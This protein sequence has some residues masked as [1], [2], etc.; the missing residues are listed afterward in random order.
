MKFRSAR[1][2][3]ECSTCVKHKCLLRSLSGHIHARQ[4]QQDEYH[5][6]L[7]SQY[8]DRLEYWGHRGLSRSCG[9]DLLLIVDGM[10]QGKFADPRHRALKAKEFA[11]F[12]R[13]RAHVIGCILHGRGILFAVT[14]ADLPKD[15]N[16]HV[17]LVAHALTWVASFGV[18]LSEVAVTL[19]CDNTPRECKNN[20]MLSFIASLVARGPWHGADFYQTLVVTGFDI[21]WQISFCRVMLLNWMPGIIREGGLASLRSGHSHEDIDQ[22]FGRLSA[23]MVRHG[24]GSQTPEDFRMLIS[25]FLLESEFPYEPVARRKCIK[26]DQTRDWQI[27]CMCL[28]FPS[29]IFRNFWLQGGYIFFGRIWLQGGYSFW[30]QSI[31]W[32]A[33]AKEQLPGPVDPC[34]FAG[35]RGTWSTTCVQASKALQFR[36]RIG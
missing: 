9:T 10:D 16:T 24:H 8:L 1:Q 4:K 20:V 23:F 32:A 25:R 30:F 21:F 31:R 35:H 34:A 26:I 5:R 29:F 3:P 22:A 27:S 6:H 36:P 12:Q 7:H 17:E 2:H 33:P 28:P 11:N 13:P 19:Q 15:A 18:V 14:D